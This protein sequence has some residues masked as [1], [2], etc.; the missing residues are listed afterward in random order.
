M[1]VCKLDKE[2]TA[3]RLRMKFV[4]FGIQ[5]HSGKTEERYFPARTLAFRNPLR[6]EVLQKSKSRHY[7]QS[8][9]LPWHV[10]A[11]IDLGALEMLRNSQRPK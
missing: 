10:E 5:V 6:S 4:C 9:H 2:N 1:Y 3:R 8:L 7:Q 11:E